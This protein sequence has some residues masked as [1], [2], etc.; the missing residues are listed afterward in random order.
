MISYLEASGTPVDKLHRFARFNR[1]DGG[2]AVFGDAIATEQKAARHIL[3]HSRVTF[4]QL[5]QGSKKL[6]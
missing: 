5:V 1:T 3:P 4:H 6:F 2:I